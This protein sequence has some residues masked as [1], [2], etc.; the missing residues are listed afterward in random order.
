MQTPPIQIPLT[1]LEARG[2]AARISWRRVGDAL[3]HELT[4]N[5]IK[6]RRVLQESEVAAALVLVNDLDLP[7][8]DLLSNPFMQ[9]GIVEARHV[10]TPDSEGLL[11]EIAALYAGL[12]R[13]TSRWYWVCGAA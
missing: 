6:L 8:G 7:S 13:V 1:Q 10:E 11:L 9:P 4:D 3:T 12:L 2:W 5:L